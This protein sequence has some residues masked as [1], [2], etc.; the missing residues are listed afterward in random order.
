MRAF[1]S[2]FLTIVFAAASVLL[3]TAPPARGQCEGAFL[4]VGHARPGGGLGSSVTAHG[5][6][7]L[8]G[9]PRNSERELVSGA[10]Y[11]FRFDGAI[12]VEK[13]KLFPVA[14]VEYEYFGTSVAMEANVAIV[15][16]PER[17]PSSPGAAYIF[18]YDGTIDL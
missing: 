9:S 8:V 14:A 3:A 5:N 4:R 15:G 6:W 10:V 11:A 7:A 18:G 2:D 17:L 16:A 12:W 13:Q 1:K